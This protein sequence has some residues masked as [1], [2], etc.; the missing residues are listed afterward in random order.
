MTDPPTLRYESTSP[1]E[2]LDFDVVLVGAGFT[3][4]YQLR[5]LRERGFSVVLL[6]AG[7]DLGGVWN[8]N[9]YPGARVDSHGPIYQYTDPELSGDWDYS[10][11]F[12]NAAEMRDYFH[13]VDARLD[14]RKDC[15]FNTRVTACRFNSESDS[16]VVE[17][18]PGEELTTRFLILA[19]GTTAEPY[20]PKFVGADIY[21]GVLV[22]TAQWNEDIDLTDMNV[23]VIG[24]GASGIQVI[25]ESA[26][27]AKELTV[28]QR[29][30]N[31]SLPMHQR[32]LSADERAE[33]KSSLAGVHAM[34]PKTFGAIDFDFDPRNAVDVTAK[35]REEL[36]QQL[37]NA[38]GLRFWMG[39]F[40]DTMFDPEANA[41][42][43]E[44]WKRETRIKISDPT[45]I[46]ILA[47]TKAPHPFG[48][49]RPSLHQNYYEALSQDNV[50]IVSVADTPIEEFTHHGIRVADGVIR[51]FD[52]IILATGFD[53]NTGA[54]NAIDIRN[55]D[56][57]SLRE[58]WDNG[59]D[60][61]LGAFTNGFPNL[62]FLYGPQSPAAFANGATAAELQG[63]LL[64]DM[65][66]H[67]RAEGLT[68]FESTAKADEA[69]TDSI[70]E[71]NEQALFKLAKSWYNASNI[72]GKRAQ[73]LQYPGG[74]PTYRQHWEAERDAGYSLGLTLGR[75]IK[76]SYS[77]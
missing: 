70:E 26:P 41:Y 7:D 63:D 76:N 4:L 65:L 5:R 62:A 19:T 47:P 23:A 69:W 21:E 11:M 49:K 33:I 68:H 36:Y 6:E 54:I 15:R 53:T 44:F 60:A 40:S 25:Q 73:L 29:T 71:L 50:E 59:V 22:H 14:L 16:W 45:K 72:P 67:L 3:G 74:M 57:G 34:V 52:V 20:I 30:P 51:E 37:W 1:T 8:A 48:A 35:E 32:D 12:P 64:V 46:E 18:Q 42:A 24:T 75:S 27:I 56:G 58:K 66:V 38:G 39:N 31:L 55:S 77:Y 17:T 2:L 61:Y 9:R 28:F 13:Y 43:Y 10:Q